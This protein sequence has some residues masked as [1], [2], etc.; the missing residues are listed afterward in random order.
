MPVE[1]YTLGHSTHPF[2]EFLALLARNGIGH[3]ADVRRFPGS[4]KFPQY[5]RDDLSSSL[6]EAGIRYSWIEAL[7]GRRGRSARES[8]RNLGLRNESFR[9]YADYMA[10]ETFRDGVRQLLDGAGETRTAFMCSESL[11]WRCH[12]R[13]ISDALLAKG[14]Q[15]EHIM[16]T[17]ELRPHDLTAGAKVTDGDVTYPAPE[18]GQTKT[19]FDQSDR[20]EDAP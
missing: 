2:P 6:R 20:T 12:R 15:V 17:G 4:R 19:L 9:N 11:F 1:L 7:G 16:P 18:R 10:T 8:S 14:I 5:N 13:L 3:V